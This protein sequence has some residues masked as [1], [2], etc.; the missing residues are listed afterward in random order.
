MSK[1][2]KLEILTPER[3]FLDCEVEAVTV[4]APDGELTVLADHAPLV[5]TMDIGSIR[6]KRDGQWREAFISE[7]F[8]EVKSEGTLIFTQACEWP[9][10]IDASRALAAEKRAAERLRQKQSVT[11]Y[12]QT[13]IALSRAMA[14]LRV[15]KTKTGFN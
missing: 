11:E 7:G 2:F 14:R 12:K 6:I 9:E 10:E 1:P 15:T 4:T 13:K 3:Q 8:I 5:A